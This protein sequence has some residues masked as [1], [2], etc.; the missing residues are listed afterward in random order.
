MVSFSL[1]LNLHSF[2]IHGCTNE[3]P[4]NTVFSIQQKLIFCLS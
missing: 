2:L 3:E 1:A 4:R